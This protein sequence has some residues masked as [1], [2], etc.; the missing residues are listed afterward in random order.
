VA[1]WAKTSKA[2]YFFVRMNNSTRS[3]PNIE[4]DTYTDSHW[5]G[6]LGSSVPTA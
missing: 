4:I 6:R 3:L 1:W 5:P 2:D